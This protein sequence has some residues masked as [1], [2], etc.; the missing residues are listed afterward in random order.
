MKKV[1]LE[2]EG[3]KTQFCNLFVVPCHNLGGGLALLWPSNM[4]VDVQSYFDDHIDVI[5][6][7]GVDDAWRFTGFYGDPETAS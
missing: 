7:H 4:S 1:V 5:F 3:R 6:D 2:R